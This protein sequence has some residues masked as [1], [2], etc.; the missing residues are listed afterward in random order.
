LKVRFPKQVFYLRGNHD[1]FSEDIS[2]G[3]IPQGIL[4]ENELKK[5]RGKDYLKGMMHFYQSLPYVAFSDRFIACHAA[6]PTSSV[7]KST[8]VNIR[9][10]TKLILELTNNRLKKPNRPAGYSK[11]DVKRFR[12]LLNVSE[13][14]PVIVGH[15]PMSMDDTLWENVGEIENHIVAYA[16]DNNWVGVMAQIHDRLYPLRYP[17]EPVASIINSLPN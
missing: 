5:S 17:V 11:R 8:L 14:T 12:K 6:A 2:K 9:D 10:N 16:A 3:G 13:E 1:S 15:T 7:S 4:W